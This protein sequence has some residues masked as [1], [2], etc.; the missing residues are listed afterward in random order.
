MPPARAFP[1]LF[2]RGIHAATRAWPDLRVDE[3][4]F[5]A[6]LAERF[7]EASRLEE[8]LSRGWIGDLYLCCAC[9]Q[10]LPA[11]FIAMESHVDAVTAA[12]RARPHTL[13]ADELKQRLRERLFIGT[14]PKIAHYSGRG[15]FRHW[16]KVVAARVRI[17]CER[18]RAPGR[19]D[20]DLL[21]QLGTVIDSPELLHFKRLY[22]EPFEKALADAMQSL[23]ERH[24]LYLRQYYFDGLNLEQLAG[25]H[26]VDPSTV[27]RTLAK[28][29]SLV[30]RHM[31]RA[32]TA[33][34]QISPATLESI[35]RLL[36]NQISLPGAIRGAG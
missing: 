36:S 2:Q 1:E 11:A 7:P 19:P 6:Y 3:H 13:P 15:D 23:P 24:L 16:L 26:H 20:R 17:D 8:A 18:A 34:L 10:G 27:S 9:M 5:A 25:L 31:R 33:R 32:L 35:L 12:L 30:R 28:A 14:P 4:V 22:R 21:R 29:A